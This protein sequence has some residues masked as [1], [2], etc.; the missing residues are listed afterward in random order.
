MGADRS[1]FVQLRPQ[2]LE[3]KVFALQCVKKLVGRSLSLQ[4]QPSCPTAID[5]PKA[6]PLHGMIVALVVVGLLWLQLVAIFVAAH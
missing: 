2:R 3:R 5:G 4:A 6:A 1:Q